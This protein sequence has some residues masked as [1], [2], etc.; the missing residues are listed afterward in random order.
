MATYY[1]PRVVTSNLVFHIDFANP[2]S[3]TGNVV[4]DMGPRNIPVTLINAANNTLVVANGYAQF[5]SVSETAQS[6]YYNI[7]NSYF[8]TIKNEVTMECCVWAGSAVTGGNR[9]ISTRTSETGSFL[10]F[11][12]SNTNI[13]VEIYSGG[14]WSTRTFGITNGTNNW[15]HVTQTTSNTG[16]TTI[17]YVNGANVGAIAIPGTLANSGGFLLG[18]GFY[19]GLRYSAG[20]VSYLRVYDRVLTPK[21]IRQNFNALRGRFGI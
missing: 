11:S 21:E 3:V 13:S 15:I 6:T 12:I 8:N 2:R 5:S 1:N 9:V 16:N 19:G 7:A 18:L 4:V 10:G 14:V 20:R 17:T